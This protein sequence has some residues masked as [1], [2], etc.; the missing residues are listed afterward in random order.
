MSAVDIQLG[1][2]IQLY[3]CY[4]FDAQAHITDREDIRVKTHE[5]AVAEAAMLYAKRDAKLGFELWLGS[6]L[7]HSCP[8]SPSRK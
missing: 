8:A 1:T 5:E 6:N 7:I 4:F 2:P 3:R